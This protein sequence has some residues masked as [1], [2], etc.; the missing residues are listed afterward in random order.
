MTQG[1]TLQELE[2]N[3][4]DAYLIM[5]MDDVPKKYKVKEISI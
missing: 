4:R 5:A 2:G 3:I 1:K